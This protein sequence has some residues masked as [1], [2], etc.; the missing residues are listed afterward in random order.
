[1]FL[2]PT[3]KMAAGGE[4][5]YAWSMPIFE[6][7]GHVPAIDPSAWIAPTATVIGDVTI[8]PRSSIW[9]GAVLRG[10]VGSIE[11]GR[12][13]NVQD[14]ATLH[15]IS[16]SHVRV[17]NRVSIAHGCV[18]HGREIG[19][20]TVIGN[21]SIVLDDSVVGDRVLVAAGSLVTP[22]TTVPSGSLV[23]GAP[24][25]VIGPVVEGSE[26][27]RILAGNAAAYVEL[28]TRHRA[29]MRPISTDDPF[30]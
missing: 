6:F 27:A 28:A 21:G 2:A 8:G 22:G 12:E 24:A 25:R 18:I 16:G 20:G 23:R 30:S 7:E 1:M 15:V 19:S 29:G 3:V 11:I 4:A 17:G 10:D 5:G 26:A 9:Y 13:S 14:N